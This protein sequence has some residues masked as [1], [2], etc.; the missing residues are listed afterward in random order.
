MSISRGHQM[1]NAV[2]IWIKQ[3]CSKCQKNPKCRP[4]SEQMLLCILGELNRKE[5]S[6][7]CQMKAVLNG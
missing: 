2:D 7:K 1:S 4:Y 6:E 3:K 5:E